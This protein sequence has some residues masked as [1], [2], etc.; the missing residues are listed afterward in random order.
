MVAGHVAGR[1]R[2]V[3]LLELVGVL[4]IIGI[5]AMVAYPRINVVAMN[6]DAAARQVRTT[7]QKAQ[8]LAVTRQF[9]VVVSFDTAN[10]TVRVLE[11]A[12]NNAVADAT[13]TRYW[14]PIETGARFRVPPAGVSGPTTTSVEGPSLT[15][16][17][18]FPSVIFRRDGS[19]SSEMAIYMISPRAESAD[20]R[21]VTVTSSTGR[22]DWWKYLGTWKR[23]GT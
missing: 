9:D 12:N 5:L 22:A 18:G 10:A 8:R 11:D 1:R 6:Q 21:A 14:Y 19:A 15:T 16:V 13:E 20:W 17:D 4:A 2:G 23:A 3:S 7:I